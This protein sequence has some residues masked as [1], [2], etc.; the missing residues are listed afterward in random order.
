MQLNL[1][2]KMAER[3]GNRSLTQEEMNELNYRES[4]TDEIDECKF[5]E[6]YQRDIDA[7]YVKGPDET[8][9]LTLL[10]LLNLTT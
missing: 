1:N 5:E 4:N 10:T 6:Q 7:D 2:N 9:L 3:Q 8:L